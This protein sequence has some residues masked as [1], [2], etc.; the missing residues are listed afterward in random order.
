LPA[1]EADRLRARAGTGPDAARYARPAAPP[2]ALT[3]ALHDGY[4]PADLC[5]LVLDGNPMVG[6][7]LG[8]VRQRLLAA[9][10]LTRAQ[11]PDG[12]GF[13]AVRGLIALSDDGGGLRYPA[14]QFEAGGM[15]WPAVVA[16]N[17]LLRADADPWGAADWW[18]SD[19]AWWGGPPAGLLGHARDAELYAAARALTGQDPDADGRAPADPA[20]PPAP[21]RDDPSNPS[22]PARPGPA[23]P[24]PDRPRG[25]GA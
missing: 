20:D 25:Q 19:H 23:R 4:S 13:P 9:P 10:A 11:V 14:F 1:A 24:G 17:G 2:P 18:L 22:D 7:V 12:P 15:P 21:E 16:V 8:R 6:P 3:T 5:L